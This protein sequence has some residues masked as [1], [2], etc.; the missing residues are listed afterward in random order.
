MVGKK[1]PGPKPRK[2]AE[3][4]KLMTLPLECSNE[5]MEALLMMLDKKVG[6][7]N[8]RKRY[9]WLRQQIATAE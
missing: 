4:V 7:N 9:E 3:G 2:R 6:T 5:E 1:R 8:N